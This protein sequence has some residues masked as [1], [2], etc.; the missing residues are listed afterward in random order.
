VSTG[1][2]GG[3]IGYTLAISNIGGGT[4]GSIQVVDTLPTGL[5][6]KPGSSS[7]AAGE[8]VVSGDG[9]TLTWNLPVGFTIGTGAT[10]SFRFTTIATKSSPGAGIVNTAVV[11]AA[12]DSNTQNDSASSDPT[13]VSGTSVYLA[14]LV[15]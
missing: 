3:E 14:M 9:R 6:Y 10:R 11:H 4:A 1:Q 2:L 8:P 15:R 12:G 7:A 13:T 5:T